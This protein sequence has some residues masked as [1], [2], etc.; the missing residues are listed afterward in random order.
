MWTEIGNKNISD[1]RKFK[2]AW[3]KKSETD[4]DIINT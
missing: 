2:D 3:D 1:V 4:R